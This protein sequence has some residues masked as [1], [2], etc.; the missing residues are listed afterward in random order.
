MATAL[1]RPTV[2]ARRARSLKSSA[3]SLVLNERGI[4]LASGTF[5][6][7]SSFP[8]PREAVGRV[9]EFH[10]SA[11]SRGGGNETEVPPTHSRC[12]ASACL[13]ST[14]AAGPPCPSPPRAGHRRAKGRRSA[15]GYGREGNRISFPRCVCASEL[16]QTA[17]VAN[18]N[19]F[20]LR[21]RHSQS[22]E[23]TEREEQV[24]VPALFAAQ[25]KKR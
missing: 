19:P 5:V 16:C 7:V 6:C 2:S 12:F 20:A 18:G 13:N 3:A 15:N 17:R 23:K 25:A 24:V 22:T 4:F 1:I 14:A 8:S 21:I 10:A 9:G 11:M